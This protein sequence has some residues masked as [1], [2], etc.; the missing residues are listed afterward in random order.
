MNRGAL[1]AILAL[2]AP[3]G[4]AAQVSTPRATLGAAAILLGT[5]A[6]PM[7]ASRTMTEARLV[8]PV[9]MIDA[10][11]R[12]VRFTGMLNFEALTMDRGQLT[13]GAWGEGFEDRRHPH[14]FFHEL[15]LSLTGTIA[16]GVRG[17]LSAGKGFAPFGTDDPMSRPVVL[18]PI[19]HHWSQIP[20]RAIAIAGLRVPHAA[21][22]LG[23]FN[24]DE[25]DGPWSWPNWPRFG[26]SWSARVFVWPDDHWELQFS[27]ASVLSPEHRAAPYGPRDAKWSASARF[28]RAD[29]A[30]HRYA[31]VEF[32]RTSE[33]DPYHSL[34]VETETARGPARSYAR[35]EISERPEAVRLAGDPFRYASPDS[36]MGASRWY[37]FTVGWARAMSWRSVRFEPLVEWSY[38]NVTGIRGGFDPQSFYGAQGL[39]SASLCVRVGTGMPLHRMGRYGVLHEVMRTA[40]P[41]SMP[42]M[43]M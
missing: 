30:G 8:E 42:G 40:P 19:N 35:A 21:L 9:G 39:W 6:W 32:A 27:H 2:A 20:E 38:A 1:A 15:M 33:S 3:A 16:G 34:L 4:L 37:T 43:R 7:P 17:S 10:A 22:E 13:P 18:Y 5:T 23:T 41:D 25:P 24:G 28:S 26:D 14:T 11:W 31:L 29:S 12:D 36:L